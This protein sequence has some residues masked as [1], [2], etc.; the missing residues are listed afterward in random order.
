MWDLIA[1]VKEFLGKAL[2]RILIIAVI[3]GAWAGWN[4][5]NAGK[6]TIDNPTDQAITFTLDGKEYTLQ[7][8]KGK[9][10]AL[11]PREKNLS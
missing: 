11:H 8:N 5:F 9:K 1:M 6:T 4:W 2:M 3:V 7:L 10:K